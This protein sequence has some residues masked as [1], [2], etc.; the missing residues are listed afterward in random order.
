[1]S[2]II[3]LSDRAYNILSA[4][5]RQRGQSLEELLETLAMHRAADHDLLTD[6]RYENLRG[7]LPG[8]WH[9]S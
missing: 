6:P 2:H 3:E 1:M 4:L 5:A 7:I 8:T 9:V